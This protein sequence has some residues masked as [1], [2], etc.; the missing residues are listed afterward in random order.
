[1]L[2]Y[3]NSY[4]KIANSEEAMDNMNNNY[5][6]EYLNENDYRKKENILFP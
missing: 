5:V 2:I 6:I 1:M 4:E 3:C